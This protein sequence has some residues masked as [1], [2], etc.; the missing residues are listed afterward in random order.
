MKYLQDEEG[1]FEAD[2]TV[3]SGINQNH[4][5]SFGRR[6]VKQLQDSLIVIKARAP[7]YV[8]TPP[9]CPPISDS[10]GG[11]K[12]RSTAVKQRQLH[13][14]ADPNREK[15][16]GIFIPTFSEPDTIRLPRLP[17]PDQ[18]PDPQRDNLR[19]NPYGMQTHRGDFGR[20][21]EYRAS[22][23]ENR[24]E[25]R[26]PRSS[27]P[28]DHFSDRSSDTGEVVD[29][30]EEISNH[31]RADG[32]AWEES[33]YE[34]PK[35]PILQGFRDVRLQCQVLRKKEGSKDFAGEHKNLEGKLARLEKQVTGC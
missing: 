14:A 18:R 32:R 10:K 34:N 31:S 16:S 28:R 26:R 6:D 21:D 17:T 33:E 5:E 15:A 11:K 12:T 1:R 9:P 24:N 23:E 35:D 19:A 20:R 22:D 27:S 8:A 29:M 30:R 4:Q 2:A 7:W 3:F 25:N 13:A